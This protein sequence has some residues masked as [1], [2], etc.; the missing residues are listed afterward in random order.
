M[1][2]SNATILM[3]KDFN[4]EE[5][6]NLIWHKFSSH[7]K[8]LLKHLMVTQEFS[9]VTLISD[10]Q[11][12]YKVH[13]FI[14]SSCSTVF[15]EMLSSSHPLNMSIYL[16]GIHH[17]ELESILQFIYLGETTFF[18]ARMKEFLDVAKDLDIREIVKN[19]VEKEELKCDQS[20]E[21]PNQEELDTH[22]DKGLIFSEVSREGKEDI[23]CSV[24]KS[25]M[26]D[27]K[28][29]FRCQ[30]CDY[31]TPQSRHLK[32]HVE[33]KHEGVK[34]PCDQ[35]NYQASLPKLLHDHVRNKH[36]GIKFPCLQ[37]DYLATRSDNLQMHIKSKHDGIKYPCQ[38][39][40]YKATQPSSLTTHV[41]RKH[42]K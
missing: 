18:H 36:E 27:E 33:I 25:L 24:S 34:Y 26:N 11:H 41:K 30:K 40:N 17:E 12:Q 19:V 2:V 3:Y 28:K 8:D 13:K 16:R 10:D 31:Y 20:F 22:K 29:V 6:Y 37:C 39:C 5:K 9:D 15:K 38:Q 32:R 23:N 35:C 21:H 7:G 14:L 1:I 42:C 4:M